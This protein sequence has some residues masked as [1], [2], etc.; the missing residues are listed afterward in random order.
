[1]LEQLRSDLKKR[2]ELINDF[3]ERDKPNSLFL[4]A[5]YDLDGKIDDGLRKLH[6]DRGGSSKTCMDRK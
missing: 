3:L 4:W 6:V 1:M 5:I 2:S